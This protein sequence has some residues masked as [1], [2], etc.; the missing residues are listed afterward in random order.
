MRI[1]GR[2]LFVAL[3]AVVTYLPMAI[4]Q[5]PN[6]V[7]LRPRVATTQPGGPAV[8]VTVDRNRVPLGDEVTFTLAPTSVGTN[9]RF[10]VTIDFGDRQGIILRTD[11]GGLTWKDRKQ[12]HPAQIVHLY[13]APGTYTYSVL[14][15]P[16]PDP[17]PGVQLSA[18]PTTVATNTLVSF[19]AQL[20]HGFP[21]MKYQF[22]FD[23]KTKTG[24]QDEPV[25]KH[26]YAAPGTY[27]AYVD[28]GEANKGPVNRFGGSTREPIQVTAPQSSRIGPN[29]KPS[30]SPRSSPRN[31]QRPPP[32]PSPK[33]AQRPSPAPSVYPSPPRE[34]TP[35][36]TP[37]P[38]PGTS[39][40]PTGSASPAPSVSASPTPDGTSS[41]GEGGTSPLPEASPSSSV[42]PTPTP[43]GP[44]GSYD[45]WWKYLLI[46]LLLLV[47]YR[48]LK[49]F[50]APR[51]TFVPHPDPGV[52]CVGTEKPLSIDFQLALNPNVTGGQYDLDAPDGGIIKSERKS[53]G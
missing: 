37:S 40:S 47:S 46:A 9:P 38:T 32:K 13:L 6:T 26:A 27:R 3:L 18:V 33:P 25:T 10:T 8:R 44:F 1:P 21:N 36:P 4:A 31:P 7:N 28:I 50:V 17:V 15:K 23:D 43:A 5:G 12:A 19:T 20:S 48:V 53:N 42:S 2:L 34:P 51:P 45:D 49:Y 11:D 35:T 41:P 14:V 39:P 22:V 52:S 16:V 30:P 24:W 29:P